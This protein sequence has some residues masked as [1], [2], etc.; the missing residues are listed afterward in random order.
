MTNKAKKET[1]WAEEDISFQS[2][3]LTDAEKLADWS[4][5]GKY[6]QQA[7]EKV[8]EKDRLRLRF[9][10]LKFGMSEYLKAQHSDCRFNFFLG[11]YMKC[12]NL[13]GKTFAG[14]MNIK[15]SELSQILHGR[16][17]PNRRIMMR[18]EIHSNYNFPAPLWF[19]V[20]AKE[21]ALELKDDQ[22]LRKTEEAVVQPKINVV[23]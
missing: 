20:L 6:R 7:K 15:P 1:K 14:E 3:S 11:S 12:L 16:R 2:P 22:E 21:K 9:L 5:F 19:E 8:S 13:S 18:L 4:A 23:I 17:D 10:R